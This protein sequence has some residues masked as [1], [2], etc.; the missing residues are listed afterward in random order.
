MHRNGWEI[1]FFQLFYL[2]YKQLVEDVNELR[3]S[4]PEG[5]KKN[6]QTKFLARIQKTIF[7]DIPQ[8]PL[9][10]KFNLGKTLGKKY[11]SWRRAKSGIGP[12]YRLFF[13]FSSKQ[14]NIIIAWINDEFTYRK[15][16]SKTDVY[17]VFRKMLD[18]G[19]VPNKYVEL[20]CYSKDPE[21]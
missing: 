8:N 10:K 21:E 5:Y 18:S 9:D 14:K 6:P 1:F 19:Q 3:Q 2:R 11:T 12:R 4:D 17:H 20:K 16:G 7:V 15:F 13:K